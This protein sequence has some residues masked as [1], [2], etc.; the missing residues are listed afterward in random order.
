MASKFE[1]KKE[2]KLALSEIGA[3][4]PWFDKD[5][6]AW[7]YSNPLYPVECEG[8]SAEE[9]IKKYPKYLEVFIE[10]RMK[11]KLD[12]VSEKKTKGKGG[13]RPGSGRPKGSKKEPT[14]QIRVPVD[15]AE[16]LKRP[17]TIMHLRTL[18]ESYS[19]VKNI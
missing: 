8:R 15:I 17:D 14:K 4:T 2:L 18:M 19:R 10:H 12:A 1:I 3:I 11:G 13:A 9:V 5:F 16:W 6:N 7:I